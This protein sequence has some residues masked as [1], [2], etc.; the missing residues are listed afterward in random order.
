M[1]DLI[2]NALAVVHIMQSTE[3]TK[4]WS[5]QRFHDLTKDNPRLKFEV[6]MSGLPQ[7]GHFT[8]NKVALPL[9][10]LDYLAAS[11]GRFRV[12]NPRWITLIAPY[13]SSIGT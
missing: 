10:R 1:S 4:F 7:T 5:A 12:L 8:V 11:R 6:E 2:R 9:A 3:M 13:Q